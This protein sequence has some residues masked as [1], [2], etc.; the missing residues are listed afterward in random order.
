MCGFKEFKNRGKS[1]PEINHKKPRIIGKNLVVSQRL[2]EKRRI[3][4]NPSEN[5]GK[6]V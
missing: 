5:E 2:K 6:K 4:G 1:T 3:I